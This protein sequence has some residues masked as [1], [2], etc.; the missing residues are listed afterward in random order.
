MDYDT[1]LYL[2]D[3]CSYGKKKDEVIKTISNANL[4]HIKIL[5]ERNLIDLTEL[6]IYFMM[7]YHSE[8]LDVANYLFHDLKLLE[9]DK[10]NLLIPYLAEYNHLEL[11]KQYIEHPMLDPS[12]NHNK[13]IID[14]E[15]KGNEKAVKILWTNKKV[16]SSLKNDFFKLYKKLKNDETSEKLDCF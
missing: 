4:K 1:F 15:R 9:N 16:K 8:Y 3:N 14:A 11:L 12:S 5:A 2:V 7:M 13:A 10:N 6:P